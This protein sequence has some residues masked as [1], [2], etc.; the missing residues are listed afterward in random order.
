M[1]KVGSDGLGTFTSAPRFTVV[2]FL[3]GGVACELITTTN[4]LGKY[5]PDMNTFCDWLLKQ[6]LSVFM[7]R[8]FEK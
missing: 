5:L 6:K 1:R 7:T 2:F 8:S 3:Y 4:F